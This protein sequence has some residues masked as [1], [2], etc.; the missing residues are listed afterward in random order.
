[1]MLKCCWNVF[2]T[3]H[4]QM[5]IEMM[6][7]FQKGTRTWKGTRKGVDETHQLCPHSNLA[8]STEGCAQLHKTLALHDTAQQCWAGEG[9][10]IIISTD[11]SHHHHQS[12]ESNSQYMY[13]CNS[14]NG[15]KLKSIP[16]MRFLIMKWNA[17]KSKLSQICLLTTYHHRSCESNSKYVCNSENREKLKSISNK[18]FL[19]K[20]AK[21][22]SK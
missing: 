21:V 20:K 6:P 10:I 9:R 5:M 3:D 19:M 12:C 4:L 14:A 7:L 16:N 8:A 1:M 13:V 17:N 15:E 18:R 11:S 2:W 22:D